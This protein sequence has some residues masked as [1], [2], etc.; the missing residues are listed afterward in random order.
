MKKTHQMLILAFGE[1]SNEGWQ[2][3]IASAESRVRERIASYE[4]GLRLVAD[5]SETSVGRG[6]DWTV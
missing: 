3:E 2:E 6:A 5:V 4:G 1:L